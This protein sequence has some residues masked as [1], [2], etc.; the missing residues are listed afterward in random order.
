LKGGEILETSSLLAKE[1]GKQPEGQLE[2]RQGETHSL[3]TS[4]IFVENKREKGGRVPIRAEIR[5]FTSHTNSDRKS[6]VTLLSLPI[7]SGFSKG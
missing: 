6:G 2:S 3:S 5:E 4:V 1:G 7:H